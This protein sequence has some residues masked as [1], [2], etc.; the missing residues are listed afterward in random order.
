MPERNGSGKRRR[1]LRRGFSTGTA[2]TAA[3]VAALR[4]LAGESAPRVV[5]VRLPGGIYLPVAVESA[6][7]EGDA[8]LAT[9]VKNGGDDPDITNGAQIRARVRVLSGACAPDGGKLGGGVLLSAGEGVGCVT[10][11]G[12]PVAPGEPAINPVPRRMIAENVRRELATLKRWDGHFARGE[13]PDPAN[14]PLSAEHGAKRAVF[15]PFWPN[16]SGKPPEAGDADRCLPTVREVCVEVR[17]EVPRGAELAI[18]TLN[19][20]LGVLG[21]ISILG[22]TG[23]VKPFSHEAYEETIS[24]ALSVAASNGCARVILSTGGRSERFARGQLP[25]DPPEAFVQIAD[26]FS[27]GVKE[28]LRFGFQKIIHSV[29]FG[30]AVKMA[31]GH[32]YTHA[33]S[34]PMELERLAGIAA[35][36]GYDSGFCDKIASAN[37][38]RHA[39]DLLSER[40]ALRVMEKLAREALAQSILLAGGEAEIRL[41]LFHY[42]GDLLADVSED[43]E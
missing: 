26:F 2:A 43:E 33:H 7:V 12:L 31:Q 4:V 9:V 3:A 20:R 8:A 24:A 42:D 11:P 21:G 10:K 1:N 41:L 23:I 18:H 32:G 38:A 40:S 25:E 13:A 36:E 17:I 35:G 37:T 30:K 6:V 16:A 15:V 39:L 19:P 14:V 29:F 22:T 27:F 34:V 28:A 5:A